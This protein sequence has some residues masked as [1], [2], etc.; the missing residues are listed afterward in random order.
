[1]LTVL[2]IA[3]CALLFAHCLRTAVCSLPFATEYDDVVGRG[4]H[5]DEGAVAGGSAVV[6]DLRC[7]DKGEISVLSGRDPPSPGGIRR[8]DAALRGVA[9]ARVRREPL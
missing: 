3:A 9:R 2:P 7:A 1:M 4:P 8:G 5:K 6:H